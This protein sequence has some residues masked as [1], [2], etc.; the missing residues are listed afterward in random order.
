MVLL[1]RVFFF[2]GRGGGEGLHEVF[3]CRI[4]VLERGVV[5]RF[6]DLISLR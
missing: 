2:C 5:V 4:G 3:R 6:R 1:F